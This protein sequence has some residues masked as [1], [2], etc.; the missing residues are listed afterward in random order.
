MPV[1]LNIPEAKR[2]RQ[3][4]ASLSISHSGEAPVSLD[5]RQSVQMF[6]VAFPW[7]G[8]ERKIARDGLPDLRSAT[9]GAYLA[10]I[11][12]EGMLGGE[13]VTRIDE[14]ITRPFDDDLSEI[15][16]GDLDE[17]EISLKP[18]D[19]IEGFFDDFFGGEKS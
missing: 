17:N 11:P 18:D 12:W 6:F 1:R 7:D 13:A 9:A 10:A 4:A 15:A 3:L 5:V 14:E 19:P 2:I 8:R 16:T